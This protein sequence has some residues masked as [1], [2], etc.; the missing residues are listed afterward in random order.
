MYAE[1]TLQ[2]PVCNLGRDEDADEGAA[3]TT[4]RGQTENLF[5]LHGKLLLVRDGGDSCL[6]LTQHTDFLR[7]IN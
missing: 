7:L 2:R 4:L 5:A 1:D 3:G 6:T